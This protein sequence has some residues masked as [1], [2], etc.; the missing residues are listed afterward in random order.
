MSSKMNKEFAQEVN[1]DKKQLQNKLA[2][3]KKRKKKTWNF[4]KTFSEDVRILLKEHQKRLKVLLE[5]P[6]LDQV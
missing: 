4:P 2:Y 6:I 5:S 3:W 1:L